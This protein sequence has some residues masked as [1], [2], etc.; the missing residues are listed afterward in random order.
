MTETQFTVANAFQSQTV[1]YFRTAG[2]GMN[3]KGR[4][5]AHG[6]LT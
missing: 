2:L 4:L 1:T 3:I 6:L 5:S